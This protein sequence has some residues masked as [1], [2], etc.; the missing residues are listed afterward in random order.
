MAGLG[1]GGHADDVPPDAAG[2]RWKLVQGNGFSKA[3]FLP[4]CRLV[5]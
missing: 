4:S 2:Y 5:G 3:Q 1:G